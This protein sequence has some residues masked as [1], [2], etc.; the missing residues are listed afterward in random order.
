MGTV[1]MEKR[2]ARR[3]F[4]LSAISAAIALICVP[5][6]S[7]AAT[8]GEC[9]VSS[10]PSFVAQGLNANAGSVADVVEVACAQEPGQGVTVEDPRL[11][12]ACGN[13]LTWAQPLPYAKTSGPGLNATLDAY[14]NAIVVLWSSGCS[15]RETQISA[16]LSV[17]PNTTATTTFDVLPPVATP[18]GLSAVP[19]RQVEGS[20]FGLATVI[21]AE[22][23]NAAQKTLEISASNL[24]HRCKAKPHLRW[25][26]QGKEKTGVKAVRV[27]LDNNGNAFAVVLGGPSCAVGEGLVVAELIR[28]PY[29]QYTTSFL[30]EPPREVL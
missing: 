25:I 26:Y 8:R 30:G 3:S 14:G 28:S 21:E 16:R 17:P 22:F 29:T 1:L 6:S 11:Y 10:A 19:S 12:S 18:P 27:T 9:Q 7:Q 20:E 15:G 13:Q 4:A 23:S 24:Y 5:A 2:R